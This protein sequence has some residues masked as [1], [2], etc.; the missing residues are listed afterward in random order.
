MFCMALIRL[1]LFDRIATFV[2]IGVSNAL[3]G[4]YQRPL[5]LP[6]QLLLLPVPVPV[7]VPAPPPPALP[8]PLLAAMSAVGSDVASVDP[9]LFVAVTAT[10]NVLSSSPEVSRYVAAV[11]EEIGEQVAPAESH[12]SHW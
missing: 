6:P 5:M 8:L 10:L 7:P 1:L 12:T 3:A 4:S 9:F 2:G 11:A